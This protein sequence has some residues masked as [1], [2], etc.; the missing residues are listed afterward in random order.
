[1]TSTID[2]ICSNIDQRFIA[3][4]D[5][6]GI[7][8][9]YKLDIPD[10]KQIES[11]IESLKK[12]KETYLLSSL[13]T[14]QSFYDA[15][16]EDVKRDMYV[17][18]IKIFHS[19]NIIGEL[20]RIYAIIKKFRKK[21]KLEESKLLNLIKTYEI[22]MVDESFS[23]TKADICSKCN[24]AFEIEEKTAEY[25]CRSCGHTEK[26]YGVVFEDDQ[27]F[28]QEGQRTKHGKY[29]PIKHAKC[30]LDRIQAIE[31]AEIPSDI[32]NAIKNCI[33]RDQLWI[34][35][36]S[37]NTIRSYLKELK[38]TNFNVHVPLIRKLITGLEP[39]QLTETEKQLVYMYFS[40]II[41]IYSS[42]KSDPNCPYHPFFIYKII[43]Q[44]LK[45]PK[46]QK[47]CK[48]ILS[49]IHL[50]SRTTLI[51]N[52]RLWFQICDHIPEFTKIPTSSSP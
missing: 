35:Q 1:M 9:Q 48:D 21:Y 19:H 37:C 23:S 49:C 25:I 16:D 30:W 18:F 33:N 45:E 43:E 29:D 40:T 26:M 27:F 42:I 12:T 7:Y 11:S 24:I 36:V 8:S 13:G 10:E 51:E 17:Q 39:S 5:I 46:H 6:F 31:M 38:K 52:D 2:N 20:D 44:I 28:Y 41:Q 22:S 14:L 32:I 34:E 47:R 15:K 50:Q 4:E 3:L